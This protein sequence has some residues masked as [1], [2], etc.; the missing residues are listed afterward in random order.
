MKK[1]LIIACSVM[2]AASTGL[3]TKTQKKCS[4]RDRFT[5]ALRDIPGLR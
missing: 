4:V 5:T 3:W 2:L 1:S